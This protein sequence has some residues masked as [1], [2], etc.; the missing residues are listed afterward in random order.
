LTP[1]ATVSTADSHGSMAELSL[2][3]TAFGALM[4]ARD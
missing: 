4:V 2:L 3:A 1:K